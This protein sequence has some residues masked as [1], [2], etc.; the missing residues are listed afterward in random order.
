MLVDFRKERRIPVKS[1]RN[2]RKTSSLV[3][4]QHKKQKSR[5]AVPAA[6]R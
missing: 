4:R 6:M 1:K 5:T 3:E 2:S